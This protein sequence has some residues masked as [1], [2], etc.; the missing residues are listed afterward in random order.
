MKHVEQDLKIR[1][2]DATV[3]VW[4]ENVDEP[5]L[6]LMMKSICAMLSKNGWSIHV[7]F[8]DHLD[9]LERNGKQFFVNWAT[10]FRKGINNGL[11]I[12]LYVSGRKLEIKMFE[13]VIDHSDD[14]R[15]G[16]EY[17]HDKE[18]KMPYLLRM[19]TTLT[20]NK[21]VSHLLTHYEVTDIDKEHN[22]S[23]RNI[24][25]IDK[26]NHRIR[27]E[28]CHYKPELDRA[29]WRD[30]NR[31]T[32]NGDLL[33]EY[34]T[35]YARDYNGRWCV[36]YTRYSL[37]SQ[38]YVITGKYNYI[39]RSSGEIHTKKPDDLKTRDNGNRRRRLEQ[40]LAK[41]IKL[42]DFDK[43]KQLKAQL[44][45]KEPLFMIKKGDSYYGPCGSGYTS[46]TIDAGKYTEEEVKR[47]AQDSCLTIVP[48]YK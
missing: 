35:V 7:P 13:N 42:M 24:P 44:F 29:D 14:N 4:L 21:I 33:E 5:G 19:L 26:V 8:D 22:P 43:C 40:E 23:F 38:F 37:N 2:L 31:K 27:N 47:Y 36:G 20:K 34:Q 25:A 48:L 9:T 10:R 28:S 45:G 1:L 15:H 30:S 17:I 11:E 18:A 12:K 32:A 3:D 6:K 41:A 16:G 39:V 46:S